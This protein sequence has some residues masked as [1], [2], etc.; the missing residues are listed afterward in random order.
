MKNKYSRYLILLLISFI[1]SYTVFNIINSPKIEEISYSEARQKISS[2]EITTVD[3][4]KSTQIA[5]LYSENAD[6][7]YEVEIP[8]IEVFSNYMEGV[9][10]EQINSSENTEAKAIEFKIVEKTSFLSNLGSLIIIFL[11]SIIIVVAM[12]WFSRRLTQNLT[13]N[14][15]STIGINAKT[16]IQPAN[17]QEITFNDV[18]GI[19]NE[20]AEI[21]EVVKMLKEPEKFKEMGAKI[22]KGVLLT[23]EPGTG[24]TLIAKAIANEAGVKF[25]NCAGSNFDHMYVGVGA[26]KMRELF[27]EARKNAPSI[28]FLDEIDTIAKKRYNSLK[29]E[30]EQTLNQLLTEMDGFDQTTNVI[31]IAATNYVEVLDPAIIRAG[32]FDKIINLPLPDKKARKAILEVHARNKKFADEKDEVLAE[33]AKKTSG[34]SGADLENILN[35]AATIAVNAEVN[36]IRKEDIDEAF[37]KVILGI[38]KGDK[39]VSDKE[40]HL[41]AIHEAGHAIAGRVSA[42]N[43]EILQVSI[44]PRGTAGGYT[45]FADSEDSLPTTEDLKARLITSLGGRAAEENVFNT[46]S[47]GASSDLQNATKIAHSMIYSYAMGT[48]VQMVRVYGHEDYNK[49]LEDKMYPDMEKLMKEAY[50]EALKIMKNKPLLLSELAEMLIEKS[51]LD[52]SELEELFSRYRI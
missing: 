4:S 45:L 22:P 17:I 6:V 26:S 41:V 21:K 10:E 46:I 43:R 3:L 15:Q 18:A 28:I 48:G 32:R 23:G 11:P 1:L 52:S 2:Y 37:I 39:E 16:N 42:P 50:E 33:L 12:V 20:L 13:N 31:V 34:M 36:A 47:T 24:K 14:L 44:V 19:D 29:S 7:I 40:K 27:D 9:I 25:Y 5:K 8:N 35:Q 49:K 30:S 38:S 51:T